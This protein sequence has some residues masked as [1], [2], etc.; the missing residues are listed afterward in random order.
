MA[1]ID[2]TKEEINYLKLWL[3]IA[4]VSD[5]SLFSWLVTTVGRAGIFLTVI[6]LAAATG[7]TSFI[8]STHKRIA[9]RIRDLEGL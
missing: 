9:K 8:F 5:I 1:K 7:I 4:V 3:G 6:A 2:V